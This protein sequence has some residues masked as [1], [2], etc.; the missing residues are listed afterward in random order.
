MAIETR[1]EIKLKQT[2]I[3]GVEHEYVFM[4]APAIHGMKIYHDYVSLCLTNIEAISEA[5]RWFFENLEELQ[6]IFRSIGKE[7]ERESMPMLVRMG[8]FFEIIPP[9]APVLKIIPSLLTFDRIMDLS[10]KLLAGGK[11]DGVELDED[12]MCE[13]FGED[14]MEFYSAL[15][16]AVATTYPK[17]ILPLL[18]SGEDDSTPASTKTSEKK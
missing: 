16:F 12:G 17:Y 13:L 8:V 18:E 10:R 14:P 3:G 5:F 15:F 11:I 4:K 1:K 9:V 2:S 6:E 7:N